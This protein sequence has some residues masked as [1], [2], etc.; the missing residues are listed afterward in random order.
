MCEPDPPVDA[1]KGGNPTNGVAARHTQ[2]PTEA[3]R[4]FAQP[5]LVAIGADWPS[6]CGSDGE[7][8]YKGGLR[9]MFALKLHACGRHSVTRVAGMLRSFMGKPLF[10]TEFGAESKLLEGT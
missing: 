5:G 10:D 1:E 6:A 7:L 2:R 9:T 3:V 4:L 8:Q